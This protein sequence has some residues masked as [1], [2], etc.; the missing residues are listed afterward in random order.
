MDDENDDECEGCRRASHG[1]HCAWKVTGKCVDGSEF[2]AVRTMDDE[3]QRDK[4]VEKAPLG[5]TVKRMLRHTYKYG[6][7]TAY[8]EVFKALAITC[9]A[10]AVA[11][12]LIGWKPLASVLALTL[13]LFLK[14]QWGIKKL[15]E[16]QQEMES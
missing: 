10:L 15:E 9:I 11:T 13:I 12:P 8:D 16:L 4:S 7:L 6:K 5:K 14:M 1:V 3:E 2:E